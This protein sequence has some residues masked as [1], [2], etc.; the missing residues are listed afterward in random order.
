MFN[1]E[2]KRVKSPIYKLLI[3]LNKFD[4]KSFENEKLHHLINNLTP[5][6]KKLIYG[7]SNI[8]KFQNDVEFMKKYDKTEIISIQQIEYCFYKISTIWDIAYTI[9][10]ILIFPANKEIDGK[11][12]DK[13]TFLNKKFNE[14]L[15]GS[16]LLNTEWYKEITKIRNKI[17]HGGIN[18]KTFYI[19]NNE[20]I[21]QRICFQAYDLGSNELIKICKYYT[22]NRN[23]CINFADNFFVYYTH[24]L[25]SYLFCFFEFVLFELCKNKNIDIEKDLHFEEEEYLFCEF[26]KAHESWLLSDI[27]IFIKITDS[28]IVL[29]KTNGSYIVTDI[30]PMWFNYINEKYQYFPFLM[31][32]NISEGDW[33]KKID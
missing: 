23:N 16:I 9:A 14:Y 18:I 3:Y 32:S 28:M 1:T 20:D 19:E 24:I 33:V 2:D 27:N 22:N 25:Y 10:D 8:Y 4:K 12:V 15:P 17:V 30:E 31:M 7:I 11:N 6:F 26:K 13:Y 29:E 21:K 5:S